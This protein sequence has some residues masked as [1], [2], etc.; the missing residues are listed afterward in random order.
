VTRE[1][2]STN[3]INTHNRKQAVMPDTITPSS[4]DIASVNQM[5]DITTP[6]VL[7]G[8]VVALLNG[9]PYNVQTMGSDDL[10]TALNELLR[11]EAIDKRTIIDST[12]E[13]ERL[14]A[15]I[16]AQEEDRRKF[17]RQVDTDFET[18]GRMLGEAATENNICSE[19]ED[20]LDNLNRELMSGEIAG[21]TK[22][23]TVT[24]SYSLTIEARD[25]DGA[26]ELFND[27]PSSYIEYS[28][29]YD[30]SIEED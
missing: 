30:V 4:E 9:E 13:V 17:R 19:Y 6:M 26:R 12:G 5:L 8:T 24:V 20:T 15:R 1:D 10:R 23:F 16:V 7:N 28:D 22:E 11:R 21:R 3:N 29:P 18:I 14:N 25:E 27:D 2:P